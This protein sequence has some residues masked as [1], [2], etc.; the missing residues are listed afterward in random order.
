MKRSIPKIKELTIREI[1][2][3]I[4]HI[5]QALSELDNRAKDLEYNTPDTARHH[6][7]HTSGYHGGYSNISGVSLW[8]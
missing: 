3:A 8:K 4:D 2:G 6:P 7:V 1:N 5:N